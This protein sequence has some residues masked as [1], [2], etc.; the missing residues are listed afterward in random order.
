VTA[1]GLILIGTFSD[2][3]VRAYD[4]NTGK[5]LWDR[6]LQANPEGMPSVYEVGGRQYV[7][8]CTRAG[9]VFDNIGDESMAWKPGKPEAAGYYVFALPA[10]AATE[11]RKR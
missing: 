4:E 3:T 1:G 10:N 8:F 7:V 5:V 9:K 11:G 2:R 6:E